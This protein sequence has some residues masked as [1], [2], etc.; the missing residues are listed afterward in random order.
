MDCQFPGPLVDSNYQ[1]LSSVIHEFPHT[2]KSES[3]LGKQGR[4]SPVVYFDLLPN[5]GALMKLSKY[6]RNCSG[7]VR[8]NCWTTLFFL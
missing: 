1:E 8:R 5:A 2:N 3:P 4:I 7:S 6:F